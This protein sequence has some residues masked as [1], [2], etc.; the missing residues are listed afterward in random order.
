MRQSIYVGVMG[1]LRCLI[2]SWIILVNAFVVESDYYFNFISFCSYA[3]LLLSNFFFLIWVLFLCP[4][5]S[6][7]KGYLFSQRT[8]SRF[9]WFFLEFF[10]SILGWFQP[11]VG[12]FP[13]IYSSWVHLLFCTR[14][15][16][17]AVMLLVYASSSF[18]LEVFWYHVPSFSLNSLNSLFLLENG[19][20]LFSF[21]MFIAFLL[22]LLLLKT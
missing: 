1:F 8:P 2:R 17:C 12:L 6:L 14:A 4:L 7:A 21:H 18:F 11:W 10:L 13:S 15:F 5:I 22:F 16:S 9:C 19:K 3:S 20:V